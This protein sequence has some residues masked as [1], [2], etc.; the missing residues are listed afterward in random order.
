MLWVH[1][2]HS[3]IVSRYSM[4]ISEHA[5]LLQTHT[6]VS[7]LRWI[8]T[9]P[10]TKFPVW[11]CWWHSIRQVSTVGGKKVVDVWQKHSTIK[12]Y[13]VAFKSMAYEVWN[14]MECVEGAKVLWVYHVQAI[15]KQSSCHFNTSNLGIFNLVIFCITIL[16]CSSGIILEC[17]ST[18]NSQRLFITITV[19][20]T[21]VKCITSL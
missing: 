4:R 3:E 5:H 6:T 20:Y 15:W 19:N 2:W 10:N 1:V 11:G 14:Y 21:Y 16:Q 9:W 7:L 18:T 12:K 8:G 13:I 17:F